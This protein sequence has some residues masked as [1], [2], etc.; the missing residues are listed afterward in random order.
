MEVVGFG[1]AFIIGASWMLKFIM[2]R[3][4]K[5]SDDYKELTTNTIERNTEALLEI[6]HSLDRLTEVILETRCKN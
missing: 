1:A 6:H 4:A 5:L 2:K 3:L